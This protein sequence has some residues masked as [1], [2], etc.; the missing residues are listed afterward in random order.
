MDYA[1]QNCKMLRRLDILFPNFSA[2]DTN[3]TSVALFR[4]LE[5]HGHN[6]RELVFTQSAVKSCQLLQ[7]PTLLGRLELLTLDTRGH[8]SIMRTPYDEELVIN[9]VMQTLGNLC[10]NLRYLDL[11]ISEY[12]IHI[13]YDLYKDDLDVL[14]FGLKDSLV[15]LKL[16][17]FNDERRDRLQVMHSPFVHCTLLQ[18]L[19]LKRCLNA[20]DIKAVAKLRSLRELVIGDEYPGE[21]I[22]DEDFEE[23]FQ[24]Q[25]LI[26]LEQ[27]EL[28]G[29]QNF[30]K[31]ATM[32]LFKHCPNLTNWT[33]CTSIGQ[34]DGLDE[35]VT[36]CG[37]DRLKLLKLDLMCC[38][39]NRNAIIA[40]A[41][42]GNLRELQLDGRKAKN[43]KN[44]LKQDFRDAF[45]QG[46]LVNLEVLKLSFLV[47]L[48]SEGFGALLKGSS[49][50]RHVTLM[51]L[52]GVSGY[53]DIFAECHLEHLETFYAEHCPG[54]Y[55]RDVDVLKHSCPKM[56]S[57]PKV[58]Y[59]EVNVNTN[60]SLWFTCDCLAKF[61]KRK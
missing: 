34:I 46:N 10:L 5:E 47:N 58:F 53:A 42:L 19:C 35:A 36:Y 22:S 49:K 20:E 45:H 8:D 2:E 14:L 6:I 39:L 33:R 50:L 24:Q 13:E 40:V 25:Q 32:A 54:L 56:T 37:P 23:A 11:C 61:A 52:L 43:A 48:D 29:F 7:M 9:D 26:S 59:C 27:L 4:S 38:L 15:S 18:K 57:K 17:Y 55:N 41:R 1:L 28:S 51:S 12:S 30:G 44:V 31:K 3:Y 21:D 60:A 16:G